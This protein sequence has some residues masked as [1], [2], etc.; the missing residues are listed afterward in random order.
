MARPEFIENAE[1]LRALVS[2]AT[3]PIGITFLVQ[4][5]APPETAPRYWTPLR[6]FERAGSAVWPHTKGRIRT[7]ASSSRRAPV[8]FC[9]IGPAV[10]IYP[11]GVWYTGE[12]IRRN[13]NIEG[14]C[15]TIKWLSGWLAKIPAKIELPGKQF[16]WEA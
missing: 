8:G 14:I 2:V 5:P 16:E 7:E 13:R 9:S 4:S 10:M 15:L 11:D 6:R 1:Q 12:G 3:A